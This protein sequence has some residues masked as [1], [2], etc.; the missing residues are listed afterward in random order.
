MGYTHVP[1]IVSRKR[2][3]KPPGSPPR[4]LYEEVYGRELLFLIEYFRNKRPYGSQF[5]FGWG[6]VE[7]SGYWL[8]VSDETDSV[9][10]PY[11]EILR[12]AI[13]GDE[14]R[15]DFQWRGKRL[16]YRG[17]LESLKRKVLEVMEKSFQEE[18]KVAVAAGELVRVAKLLLAEL[19]GIRSVHFY[20]ATGPVE[21]CDRCGS[22]IRQVAVVTWKDGTSQKYG[23]ECINKILA[24]DTSL[25]S[26]FRKNSKWLK[27]YTDWLEI[28][29]RPI[30]KMPH[31]QEYYGSGLYFITDDKGES[32]VS[33]GGS[34]W[35][36]DVDLEKNETSRYRLLKPG[37]RGN[38]AQK[39]YATFR[40]KAI[41]DIEKAKAGYSNQIV[42]L[43]AFLAR[44][45]EKGLVKAE[46][47]EKGG[48]V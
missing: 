48:A 16:A 29:N 42:K 11:E 17:D 5:Y 33:T 1:A 20:I 10:R 9:L 31:T 19:T 37:E 36:P 22:A 34:L 45:I 43:Q 21:T 44:I 15:I 14:R 26:L 40:A 38:T 3:G 28:L 24:G 18:R 2:E 7:P 6:G 4:N 32:L 39:D 23:S 27:R 30:E 13:D 41:E 47:I 12:V 46:A 35:H 8:K 25:K